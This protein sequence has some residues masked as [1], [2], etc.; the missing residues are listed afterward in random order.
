MVID[1]GASLRPV[2]HFVGWSVISNSILPPSAINECG[3]AVD[4]QSFPL[5]RTLFTYTLLELLPGA[6]ITSVLPPANRTV[7]LVNSGDPIAYVGEP[8]CSG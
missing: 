6:L 4:V 7:A 1:G 5:T 3:S 2:P 8:T